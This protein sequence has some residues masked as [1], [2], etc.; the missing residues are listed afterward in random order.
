MAAA[1]RQRSAKP[2]NKNNAVKAWK[3]VDEMCK[4]PNPAKRDPY[5]CAELAG[6]KP[7]T[8]NLR[9]GQ[10]PY[11]APVRSLMSD[12]VILAAIAGRQ[13]EKEALEQFGPA[14]ITKR[15][16][17]IAKAD[18]TDYCEW[19]ESG[20]LRVIPSKRLSKALSQNIAKI[21]TNQFGQVSTFE[22][23]NPM[24]AIDKLMRKHGM[25]KDSLKIEDTLRAE[26]EAMTEDEQ[27]EQLFALLAAD[28]DLARDV[29][30]VT[31][32]I[33]AAISESK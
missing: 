16:I 1:N 7:R 2:S 33:L 19:D 3:F 21:R 28:P 17:T 13:L 26:L 27:K 20:K 4:E 29:H 15:L 30:K 22:L 6:Y 9:K 25:Y 10:N 8:S 11:E 12:P 24:D 23:L 18:T 32:N 5:K 14:E 31:G